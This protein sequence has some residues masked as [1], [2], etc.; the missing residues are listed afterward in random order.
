MLRMDGPGAEIIIDGLYRH[1][2]G[3]MCHCGP[4]GSVARVTHVNLY[5]LE[6]QSD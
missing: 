5:F 2:I 1:I 3:Q 6:A 4:C